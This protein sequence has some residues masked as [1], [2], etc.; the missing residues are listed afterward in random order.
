METRDVASSSIAGKTVCII[1]LG[2]VGYPLAEAFSHH[3]TTMGYDIDEQ[4]IRNLQ[5]NPASI[6]VTSDPAQIQKAD[7]MMICIQPS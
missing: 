7:F 6:T 1:G 4:K 5:K 2:Y 3:I